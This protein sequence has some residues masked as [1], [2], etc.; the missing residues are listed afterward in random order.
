MKEFKKAYQKEEKSLVIW[1]YFESSNI[2]FSSVFFTL[3]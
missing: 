3:T 2:F 1:P